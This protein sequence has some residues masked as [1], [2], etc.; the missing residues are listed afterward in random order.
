MALKEVITK[1][2]FDT[3]KLQPKR[4]NDG[5]GLS[6]SQWILEKVHILHKEQP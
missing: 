4:S 1:T 6:R 2:V 3:A 5:K